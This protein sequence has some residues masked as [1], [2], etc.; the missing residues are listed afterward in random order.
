MERLKLI[1]TEAFET[2]N[3]VKFNDC[4]VTITEREVHE[5]YRLDHSAGPRLVIDNAI[6]RTKDFIA[7]SREEFAGLNSILNE[8]T[9]K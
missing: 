1:E 3:V 6:E 5:V 7:K 4:E 8:F 9:A 2:R